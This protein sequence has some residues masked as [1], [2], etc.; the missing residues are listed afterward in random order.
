MVRIPGFHPGDPGSSP[1]VGTFWCRVRVVKEID[2]KSIGLP[3]AQVR[4]L[5]IPNFKFILFTFGDF[6]DMRFGGFLGRL[7]TISSIKAPWIIR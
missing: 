1:G 3:P 2:L 4:T 5:P 7:F 6:L